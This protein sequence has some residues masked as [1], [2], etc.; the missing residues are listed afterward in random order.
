M[1][2][3]K[4]N[5]EIDDWLDDL[6]NDDSGDDAGEIDGDLDQSDIDALLGGGSDAAPAPPAAESAPVDSG[7][8]IAG[9]LDQSDI[10]ALLGGGGE[11][12]SA[13]AGGKGDDFAELDQ[14]DIDSLLG[15]GAEESSSAEAGGGID[16]SDID[17]LFAAAAEGGE[18]EAPASDAAGE[19][20]PSQDD[21]DQLF[22][23]IGEGGDDESIGAE[24]VSFSDVVGD[25]APA[26][27]EET[28]G[29]PDDT[30]FDDDEF[31]FG[32]LPDIPDETTT[33]TA[34][35]ASALDEDIFGGA[36]EG[37]ANDLADFLGSE[38][39]ATQEIPGTAA[40]KGAPF[41]LPV[42]MNK[43]VMTITALCLLLLV[44]GGSYFLFFK[45]DKE[46]PAVPISLQE[47]QLSG[48]PVGQPGPD[49]VPVAVN[50]PPM[51][52]DAKLMMGEA[53]EALSVE[54]SGTDENNDALNFEV[55]TPPKHGRL[56]GDVPSLTYLP[57]KD[58]PGEDYF[59]YRANDGVEASPLA[60]VVIAGPDLRP[61]MAVAKP[62]PS[63]PARPKVAAKN[64]RLTTL[65]TQPLLI[66][67]QQIWKKANKTPYNAKVSVEI[68]DKDLQ[69]TLSRLDRKT[70]RYEPDKYFGGSEMIRYRFSYAGITSQVR[71]LLINVELG[72]PPPE[73]H[74]EPLAK[75]YPV[76]ESVVLDAGPTKDDAAESLVYSWEQTSGVPVLMEVLNDDA[77]AISFVVPSTFYTEDIPPTVVRVTAIDQSGQ[78]A[79]KNIVIPTVSR[80][81]TALW[82]GLESGGVAS[83]PACPKGKCPGALLPW[84]YAD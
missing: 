68:V 22:A 64:V 53:G 74:I 66:D 28:F 23:G 80:R 35:A 84:A 12:L 27:G 40:K 77:S 21:V 5:L 75:S 33:G 76:G 42:D 71:E 24:T 56:S 52:A 55:V 51:V 69:G 38:S 45:G 47:Q 25:E 78:R 58:F 34:E 10:D 14:S 11:S 7:E 9:D 19:A 54:L 60:K 43:S 36:T 62:K 57:N 81:N 46:E 67:W 17:D 41:A 61:K 32:E 26:A 44:G 15:G 82:R 73:I 2:E 4:D 16:Q 3:E 70:H 48:T 83:E 37:T 1:A 29:L 8:E 13:D 63:K 31:D 30:G 49:E 39:D 6:E 79:V 50:V 59:E 65:S 20:E 18:A 72:D